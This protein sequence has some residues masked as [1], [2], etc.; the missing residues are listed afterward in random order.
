MVKV[1]LRKVLEK[2]PEDKSSSYGEIGVYQ[3]G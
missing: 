1:K 3:D 2:A